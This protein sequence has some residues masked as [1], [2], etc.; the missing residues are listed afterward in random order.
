MVLF[1]PSTLF[2]AYRTSLVCSHV[3]SLPDYIY[4]LTHTSG[5]VPNVFAFVEYQSPDEAE[6][7]VAAPLITFGGQQL[8][9]ERK[10]AKAMSPTASSGSPMQ[11]SLQAGQAYQRG[12]AAGMQAAQ[13]QPTTPSMMPP[14]YPGPYDPYYSPS[15]YGFDHHPYNHGGFASPMAPPQYNNMTAP[16][17]MPYAPYPQGHDMTSNGY[18][19]APPAN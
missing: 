9:V 3:F 5:G 7:A 12:L 14:Y 2:V 18:S 10:E 15:P 8:R 13:V 11:M 17:M 16:P 1:R 19:S 4:V 6:A